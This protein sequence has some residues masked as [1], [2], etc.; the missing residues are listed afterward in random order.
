[1]FHREFGEDEGHRREVISRLRRNNNQ[2]KRKAGWERII[3]VFL[4]S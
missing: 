3:P 4:L 1:M 2:E